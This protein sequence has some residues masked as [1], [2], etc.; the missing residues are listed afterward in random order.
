MKK[1]MKDPGKEGSDG[2]SSVSSGF[3]DSEDCCPEDELR[4]SIK[5]EKKI[6]SVA[7]VTKKK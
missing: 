7:P 4:N 2:E 3:S 6:K 5:K 1:G